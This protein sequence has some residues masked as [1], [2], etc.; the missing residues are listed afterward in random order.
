MRRAATVAQL[1]IRRENPRLNCSTSSTPSP[2][3]QRQCLDDGDQVNRL[4][5]TIA[6]WATQKTHPGTQHRQQPTLLSALARPENQNPRNQPKMAK[7][8][9]QRPKSPTNFEIKRK[10][11]S[12]LV[13]SLPP[14]LTCG[15]TGGFG[16]TPH[17]SEGDTTILVSRWSETF[18]RW[19]LGNLAGVGESDRWLSAV[20]C[21]RCGAEWRRFAGVVYLFRPFWA[22]AGQARR[23]GAGSDCFSVL[24]EVTFHWWWRRS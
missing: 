24:S 21:P 8:A 19:G 20:A 1:A 7:T 5:R 6:R 15:L 12:V 18:G 4:G 16:R 2:T 17:S 14:P 23:L 22:L 9:Y 3:Y 11:L 13:G 10:I